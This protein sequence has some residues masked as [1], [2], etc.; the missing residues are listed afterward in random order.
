VTAP[1][2]EIPRET[3]L[4]ARTARQRLQNVSHV[5]ARIP[6][7]DVVTAL[8][9]RPVGLRL[10]DDSAP[11]ALLTIRDELMRRLRTTGG[12]PALA[13]D[14]TR[15]RVQ[16][17]AEDW[18][19]MTEIADRMAVGRHKASPAQVAGVLIHLALQSIA[20]GGEVDRPGSV[21][22]VG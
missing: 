1:N 16:V 7:A 2:D 11:I 10:D 9:A 17:S 15:P 4:T 19:I 14:G 5:P 20:P 8:G 13:G 3:R 18:R 22:S 12:R 6:V 21:G